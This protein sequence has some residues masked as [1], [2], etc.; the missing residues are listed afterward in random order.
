MSDALMNTFFSF[1]S[2][3]TIG[4]AMPALQHVLCTFACGYSL[5]IV[6]HKFV[7]LFFLYVFG[8]G[9]RSCSLAVSNL[10]L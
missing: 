3:F 6:V 5:K 8:D 2:E 1:L 9:G 7:P 10:D 4:F